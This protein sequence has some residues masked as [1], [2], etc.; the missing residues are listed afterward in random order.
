MINWLV[1]TVEAHPDL[2]RG[3]PPPGLLNPQEQGWF[4]HLKTPPRRRNWLL[5]RWTA[6]LLLQTILGREA[7][8]DVALPE[9]TIRNDPSGAP[10]ATCN[11]DYGE[12]PLTLSISHSGDRACCAAFGL[13]E[14]QTIP[15]GLLGVDIE[16]VE[17]RAPGFA[18]EYFTETELALLNSA[19]PEACS[20]DI[21]VTATWSAKE[22]ALKAL[23]LG[24]RIDTRSVTCL[25]EPVYDPGEP[26]A[27]V[28]I[29]WEVRR[30]NRC[31]PRGVGRGTVPPPDGLPRL[32][33]WWRIMDGY[34]VT[35]ATQGDP[36]GRS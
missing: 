20:R 36:P 30:M 23:H 28:E 25:V 17:N 10:Y 16:R 8:Q 24:L 34:V 6:K 35:L 9:L 7:G 12:L 5:G 22:A 32:A 13:A 27:P 29:N 11:L 3:L 15:F 26:W 18:E 33:G 2:R 21:L 19:R 4:A 14:G 31:T 1:Q